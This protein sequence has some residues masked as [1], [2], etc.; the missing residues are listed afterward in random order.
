MPVKN[1]VG[2]THT[3]K[4]VWIG[5][6]HTFEGSVS[7]R[8]CHGY[9]PI[10]ALLT[11]PNPGH[12]FLK[13]WELDLLAGALR[14]T[15]RQKVV[16]RLLVEGFSRKIIAPRLKLSPNTIR[17]HIEGVFRKLRVRDRLGFALRVARIHQLLKERRE[18]EKSVG[19]KRRAITQK[20]DSAMG[21]T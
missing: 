12:G 3:Q 20:G 19:T 14:L 13:V 6:E 10:S 18:T 2:R 8:G 16:A 17:V 21:S 11:P 4:V 9:L 7:V 15:K 1:G 5:K